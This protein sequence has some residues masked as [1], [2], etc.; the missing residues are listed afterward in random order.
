MSFKKN[1]IKLEGSEKYFYIGAFIVI[2]WY[3]TLCIIQLLYQRPLWNDEAAVFAS[4]VKFSNK[5]FFTKVL[6]LWQVFPRGYLFLIQ[7]F[8]SFYN[9][10][11]ISLRLPSFICMIWAFFNW[12]KIV[13]KEL[14]TNHEK[15][16]YALSWASS[17][18]LIYYSSELKPYSMDVLTTSLFILFLY[19]QDHLEKTLPR[20]LYTGIVCLLPL[21]GFLSYPA[22]LFMIFPLYNIFL[23]AKNERKLVLCGALYAA[24]LF[25]VVILSY[26]FDMRLKPAKAVTEGFADYFVSL[27]S[28]G[29]FFK[30][31]GEGVVNLFSRWFA[32][33]PRIIKKISI[34]FFVF[35]MINLFYSFF[36]NIKMKKWRMDSVYTISLVVFVELFILGVF[37]KYPFSIPRTSLFFCPIVLF[38]TLKG[39]VGISRWNRFVGRVLQGAYIFFLLIIFTLLSRVVLIGNLTPIPLLWG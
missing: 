30:T 14:E 23:S 25:G 5:D 3:L 29:E 32:E 18:V 24:V 27:D 35:G 34:F 12:L 7:K 8:S 38:L 31:F 9:Y 17:S 20:G 33:R 1:L 22:F 2:F 19:R 13:N 4:I 6:E 37:K 16:I 28:V 26:L 36:A 15:F 21:L 11:L 10:H 39:L